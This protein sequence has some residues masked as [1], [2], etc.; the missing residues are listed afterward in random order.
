M[1]ERRSEDSESLIKLFRTI[2]SEQP[3]EPAWSQGTKESNGADGV[4]GVG[5]A[6]GAAKPEDICST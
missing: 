5:R 2:S 6:D 1:T 4:K 3:M